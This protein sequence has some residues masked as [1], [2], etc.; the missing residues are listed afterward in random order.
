MEMYKFR[1][2]T[3]GKNIL[4]RGEAEEKRNIMPV[5]VSI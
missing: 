4:G 5:H 1:Q 2:N 3:S